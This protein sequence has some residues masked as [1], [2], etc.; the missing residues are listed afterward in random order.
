MRRVAIVGSTGSIGRRALDVVRWHRD[1]FE[2][3]ALAA[4]RSVE[5]L[6]SQVVEFRPKVVALRDAE[7]A[8][9]LEQLMLGADT[10]VL[11]GGEGIREVAAAEGA[12]VVIVAPSGI[13]GVQPAW[14]AAGTGK[15]VGLANKES[16]VC[17]GENILS[18]ARQAGTTI[19][20]VD[21]EH[22]AIFQCFGGSLTPPRELDHIEL[23]C[24]GGPLKDVDGSRLRE[25]SPEEV[26]RHPT[27]EMGPKITVD[28]A[29]LMNKAFEIIEASVLFGV[30][31]ERVKVVIHPQSIVHSM[32]VF[33]DGSALAQLGWPDMRIPIQ[34]AMSYPDRLESPGKKFGP[35]I[36]EKLTFFE[37]D[38]ERFP[39]L[40]FG[41]E[42]SK[43]APSYRTVLV[44]ADEVAVELFLNRR[45]RFTDIPRLVRRVFEKHQPAR[46]ESL[47]DV[48]EVAEWAQRVTHEEAQRACPW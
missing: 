16:L 9:L 42:A 13:S 23:T 4:A 33:K 32:V 43:L 48:I 18:R 6:A 22:S 8:K 28:S 45:I 34:Y 20:P 3:V 39:C 36:A 21:S 12:D 14:T 19:V 25:V 5:V 38:I 37:P 2:V 44:A 11:S 29:T 7:K 1:K 26:L 24:S 41:Y 17:L 10:R 46:V 35:A 15:L 30:P 47:E 40:G 27:W 31:A